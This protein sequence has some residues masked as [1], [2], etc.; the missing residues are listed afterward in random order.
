[1]IQN[2]WAEQ[3]RS[4]SEIAE[5]IGGLID[6]IWYNRHQNRRYKIAKGKVKVVPKGTPFNP[7]THNKVIREDIWQGALKSASRVEKEY[8]VSELGP[9][10]DFEWGMLNGKLSAL[11]WVLGDDWDML[12]T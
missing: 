5:E 1:M 6:K 3:P 2:E 4:F 8:G 10:S 9:Y 11:R 7:K 12:D